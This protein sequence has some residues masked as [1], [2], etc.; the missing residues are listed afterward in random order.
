MLLPM[1]KFNGT[2]ECEHKDKHYMPRNAPP[3]TTKPPTRAR[4]PTPA[5]VCDPGAILRIQ[6][7]Q[8]RLIVLDVVIL[9]HHDLQLQ[10]H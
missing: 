5:P 1:Y 9:Q 3:L 8:R 10:D 7:V 4:W 2:D 6:D